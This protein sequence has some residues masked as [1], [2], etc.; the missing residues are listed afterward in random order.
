[1]SGILDMILVEESHCNMCK[2]PIEVYEAKIVGGPDKGKKIEITYGC[3]CEDMKLANQIRKNQIEAEKGR[4]RKV[5]DRYSLINKDLQNAKLENYKPK[6][7]TQ[8]QAKRKAIDYI[9]NFNPEEQQQNLGFFGGVGV[10]KSHLAKC[11]ADGVIEKEYTAIFVTVPKLLAKLR[12]SYNKESEFNES[13]ILEVLEK[14]DLLILDDYGTENKT[15]WAAEKLFDLINTRD[16]MNT[17]ITT[18]FSPEELF[19]VIGERD[20]SRLIKSPE[21]VV[22]V[23]GTNHR[24]KDFNFFSN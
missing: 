19:E 7:E 13:E 2:N 23:E 11:I 4:A 3:K 14:A 22:E 18:N 12:S 20:F 24:L 1:M 16:G 15:D 10:G 17:I 8:L 9:E 6:D 5:F 21:W